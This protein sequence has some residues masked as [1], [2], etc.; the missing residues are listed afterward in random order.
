M[1]FITN[2]T[3]FIYLLLNY[4]FKKNSLVYRLEHTFFLNTNL[5]KMIIL[6]LI[7]HN[8]MRLSHFIYDVLTILSLW[9]QRYFYNSNKYKM[10]NFSIE[11]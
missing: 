1:K 7:I 4:F 8:V 5:K 2:F 11:N 9:C 10:I 3:L 6:H